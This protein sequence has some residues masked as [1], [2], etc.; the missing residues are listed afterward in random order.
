MDSQKMQKLVLAILEPGIFK[1]TAQVVEEFRIENPAEWCRLEKEGEKLYGKGCSS[2]QQP[3]TCIA[4]VLL[5][6]PSR[7]RL[8]YKKD[9]HSF[10]S[11]S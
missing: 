7:S 1:T 8:M 10:W 11:K 6:L 9:G 5:S 2:L 3:S 4:Q